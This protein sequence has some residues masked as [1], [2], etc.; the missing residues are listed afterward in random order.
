[1]MLPI[2]IV[3]RHYSRVKLGRLTLYF[4]YA[5]CIAYEYDD[6]L[7]VRKQSEVDSVTTLKHLDE[8]DFHMNENRID[9]EV[10]ETQLS[11]ILK[12]HGLSK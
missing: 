2:A 12:L 5:D 9:R 10:F 6:N 3:N 11:A 4:S 8:I 7:V 1:M